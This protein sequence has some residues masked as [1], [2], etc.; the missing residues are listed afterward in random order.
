MRF[1][2]G[3]YSLVPRVNNLTSDIL[4]SDDVLLSGGVDYCQLCALSTCGLSSEVEKQ[5]I[6]E[7]H[8]IQMPVGICA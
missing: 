5:Y 1:G 7:F 6:H 8:G 4:G 3:A 2:S